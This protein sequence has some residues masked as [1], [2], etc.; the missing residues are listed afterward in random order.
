MDKR[1]SKV[2]SWLMGVGAI[3]AGLAAKAGLPEVV[4]LFTS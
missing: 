4:S 1:L 2:E 3:F